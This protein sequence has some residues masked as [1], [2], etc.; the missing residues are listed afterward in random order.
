[1]SSTNLG[2][3]C[4]HSAR[5]GNNITTEKEIQVVLDGIVKRIT[6]RF[7][8]E[9]II[10]FGSYA[11]GT[12]TTDSDADLLIVMNVPGSKRKANVEIDLLLVGIPIPTDIIVV[13]PEEVE[14]HRDCLG[15]VIREAIREG[16]VLYERA[17]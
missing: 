14:R 1:M 2:I 17:A 13:T 6:E 5:A 11:R 9:K 3:M 8:P 12:Q 7:R 15:T 10:L 4:E 16:K